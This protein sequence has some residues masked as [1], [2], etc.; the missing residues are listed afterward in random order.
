MRFTLSLFTFFIMLMILTGCSSSSQSPVVLPGPADEN[1]ESFDRLLTSENQTAADYWSD[2]IFFEG[3][4]W[5]A[6]YNDNGTLHRAFGKGVK[7]NETP[8]QIIDSHQKFFFV[9]SSDLTKVEEYTHDGIHY[10][11]YRQAINGIQFIDSRVELR[12]SRNG[13]L[14][15]IGSDVFPGVN[16]STNPGISSSQAKSIVLNSGGMQVSEPKLLIKK[17]GDNFYLAWRVS[18]GENEYFIS[19]QDGS[20]LQKESLLLDDHYWTTKSEMYELSPSTP[21]NIFDYPNQLNKVDLPEMGLVDYYADPSGNVRVDSNQGTLNVASYLHSPWVLAIPCNAPY[22]EGSIAWESLNET[23]QEIVF[24]DSN[25]H[26]GERMVGYWSNFSHDY[27]KNIDPTFTGMDFPLE[28][29]ADCCCTCN[30]FAYIEPPYKIQMFSPSGDCVAT[31]EIADVIAHEYG[32][33]YVAAQYTLGAPPLSIHEAFAD[34]LGN[35]TTHQPEIGKDV[36]GPGTNFRSSVNNVMF[37]DNDCWGESHCEGN[38]LA[39]ALWEIRTVLGDAYTD[40]VWHQARYAQSYSFPDYV[41]DF[42]MIDDDDDNILNGTPNKD[43]YVQ[44]FWENHHIPVPEMPDIPTEGVILDVVPVKFPIQMDYTKQNHLWYKITFTNLNAEPATFDAW[45]T[46]YTPWD[47]WYGPII[48]AS[49][50]ITRPVTLT[51]QPQQVFEI[52]LRQSI[53]AFIPTG[54]YIYHVRIGEYVD[55]VNDILLDDGW[56]KFTLY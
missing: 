14:I 4:Y 35:A 31:S 20:I 40:H 17:I 33:I 42:F 37:D 28:C 15:L 8:E 38:I 9:P 12:Y 7:L 21:L 52:T 1:N 50:N 32:H 10:V 44:C 41:V 29:Y 13:N 16:I 27:I 43:L 45:A 55:H 2:L 19:A 22:P 3:E 54:D 36:T 34:V 46:V 18:D 53:P 49:I 6:R 26:M 56:I 47:M 11:F 25:S 5:L 39:G 24:D 48:P 51:L 30:A 23:H